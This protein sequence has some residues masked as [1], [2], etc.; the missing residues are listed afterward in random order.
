MQIDLFGKTDC[1][2]CASAKRKLDHFLN[3]WGLVG[4]VSV[5][6]FDMET[7]EG[8]AEGAL[9]DVMKIPTLIIRDGDR[10]IARW[11][12]ELPHS[13]EIRLCIENGKDAA[14]H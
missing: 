9:R 4:K 7:I 3:K 13:E 12:G 5:N 6:Y 14:A 1:S 2:K 8:R 10:N 11:E